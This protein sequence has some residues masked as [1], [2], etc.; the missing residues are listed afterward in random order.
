MSDTNIIAEIN[1]AEYVILNIGGIWSVHINKKKQEIFQENH[2]H[3]NCFDECKTIINSECDSIGILFYVISQSCLTHAV[4]NQWKKYIEN[5]LLNQRTA[6][7][8]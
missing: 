2:Y 4:Y 7:K 1:N 8:I 3:T 6:Y 5:V